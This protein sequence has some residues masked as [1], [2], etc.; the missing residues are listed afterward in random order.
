MQ[1]FILSPNNG[2]FV[3]A[4]SAGEH[5]TPAVL[6]PIDLHVKR[7]CHIDLIDHVEVVSQPRFQQCTGHTFSVIL[8]AQKGADAGTMTLATQN[9]E[10]LSHFLYCLSLLWY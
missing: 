2:L 9:S 4:H 10:Q 8:W 6:Q 1:E 5:Y 7:W 3:C